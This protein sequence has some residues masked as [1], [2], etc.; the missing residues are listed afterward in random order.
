[1]KTQ[2]PEFN[3]DSFIKQLEAEIAD[4]FNNIDA[5]YDKAYLEYK[6]IVEE[7]CNRIVSENEI[8]NLLTN[9]FE[10]L[11]DER[12]VELFKR[13]SRNYYSIYPEL[14]T[15]HVKDYIDVFELDD[16]TCSEYEYLF[17]K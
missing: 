15:F 14:I 12:M 11:E 5:L 7:M 16:V 3:E 6:S 17:N 8:D 10:F 2:D 4:W 13:I 9:L 1:M